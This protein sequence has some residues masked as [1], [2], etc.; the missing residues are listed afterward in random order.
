ME[1]RHE[2]IDSNPPCGRLGFCET[3]DLTGNGRPDVVVGGMG[4]EYPVDLFGK[5]L[6]LR[7]LPVIG[8]V[9]KRLEW[10]VFWY[11][12]PGWE[13]HEVAVA[14]GLS[15]GATIAD[16]SGNGR[17][18]LVVGQNLDPELYWFEQPA[19]PREPW[20]RH[21]IT[22]DYVKYHDTAVADV[23][24]DG[25]PELV[26]LS[27]RSE[28]VFYYDIPE[29]PWSSPWPRSH[30]H[31][32]AENCNV[33]G[34]VIAD[35]D[36]DGRTELVAGPNVFHRRSDDTWERERLGEDWK[37]TRIAAADLTGD[38]STDLVMTEGDLPY[39]ADRPGRLGYFSGPDWTPTVLADDLSNPHSLQVADFDGTGDPDIYVAE[40]GLGSTESP[41]HFLFRNDGAGNF[42][43][44][45]VSS[46]IPTHEAKVVDLDGDDRLDIVGKS[47]T[48]THHVDAW[49]RND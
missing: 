47:Y 45:L 30:R 42:D 15:V 8:D 37:W 18:D 7:Y 40:M 3:T 24:D 9:V 28:V 6:K 20:T 4:A 11:E 13:R 1:F 43:R 17:S 12:N 41:R 16:V 48:P 2:R 31:V 46:G 38:G 25:E 44:T 5:E 22:D 26:V 21:L 39:H 14:P 35:V 23:D 19:D 34:V 27:Q 10:N 36:G 33:E 32:V 49:Y 29:D